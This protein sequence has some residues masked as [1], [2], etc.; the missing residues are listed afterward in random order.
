MLSIGD[1]WT[2]VTGPADDSLSQEMAEAGK[3]PRN[4]AA[5]AG[6]SE[7]N[8]VSSVLGA[9]RAGLQDRP[10]FLGH[11]LLLSALR[12]FETRKLVPHMDLRVPQGSTQAAYISVSWT[13]GVMSLEVACFS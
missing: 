3:D 8:E 12:C 1:T 4:S 11:P 7:H 6:S 5:R 13:V 10:M 2:V 9:P